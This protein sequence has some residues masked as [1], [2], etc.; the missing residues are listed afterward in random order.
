M[1]TDAL[2]QNF[3]ENWKLRDEGEEEEKMTLWYKKKSVGWRL[4]QDAIKTLKEL[5]DFAIQQ[6]HSDMLSVI[7]QNKVF[8]ESQA[9]KRVN[10]WQNTLFEFL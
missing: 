7:F 8:V 9:A 6:N 5:Q 4:K 10:C 3:R 2:L 1:N